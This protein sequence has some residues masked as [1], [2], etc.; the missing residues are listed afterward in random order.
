MTSTTADRLQLLQEHIR[1]SLIER[2]RALSLRAEPDTR[3]THEISRSLDTLHQGIEQ[4]E[5]EQQQLEVAGDL[6]VRP[7]STIAPPF[8]T[9]IL[10][11]CYRGTMIAD[12]KNI[13]SPS[14]HLKACG[15]GKMF[16]SDS[17]HNTMTYTRNSH[18]QTPHP[19]V[20]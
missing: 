20:L 6:F 14:D 3:N 7:Y 8:F 11:L 1:L 4:L 19:Q 18:R 16:L 9:Y 10:L 15:K 2:K 17:V 13:F 5:K 12:V